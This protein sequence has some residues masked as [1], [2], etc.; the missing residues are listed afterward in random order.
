MKALNEGININIKEG[1]EET[2]NLLKKLDRPT[3]IPTPMV[4][5]KI[6]LNPNISTNI[7]L[8]PPS[9]YNNID[10]NPPSI[11]NNMEVNPI[12]INIINTTNIV[13]EPI[14]KVEP[15]TVSVN[16]LSASRSSTLILPP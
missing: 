2:N 14:I 15:S 12:P 6:D 8:N 4:T 13:S 16:I 7:D 10:M 3:I 5:N 11:I 9:I 1:L